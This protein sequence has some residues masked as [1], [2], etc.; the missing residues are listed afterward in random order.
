AYHEASE[1]DWAYMLPSMQDE[2]MFANMTPLQAEFYG[3]LMREAELILMGVMKARGSVK[4]ADDDDD[5]EDE[6]DDD[7]DEN[8]DGDDRDEAKLVAAAKVRLQKVEMFLVAP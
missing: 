5:E 3:L 4:S 6:D 2:I 8:P 7:D 1:E